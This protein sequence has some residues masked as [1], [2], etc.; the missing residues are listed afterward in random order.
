MKRNLIRRIVRLTALLI[1]PIA[2]FA[3]KGGNASVTAG[4]NFNFDTGQVV[5]SGGDL[6]FTGSSLTYVGSAKGGVLPGYTGSSNY[7]LVTPTILQSLA[8]LASNTAI[9]SSSLS[10]GTANGS[11]LGLATNGG[12]AAKI[13]ITGLGPTSIS[14]EYLTYGA[15]GTPSL[16]TI[17]KILNN[18]S[19]TPAGFVNSGIAPSSIATIFGTNLSGPAPNPLTLNTSAGSGL[20]TLSN[21]AQVTISVGGKTFNAGIYYAIPTQMAVVIPASIPTGTV[22]VTVSNG[23]QTS[24][25][26][27]V[28][29]VPAALGLDTYYGIGAGLITATDAITGALI[30]PTNS[31]KPG[32][33]ITLWGSG[34]GSD[35]QDS[36][37]VFTTTP[38]AVN[39]SGVQI[40][41]GG[42][43]APIQYAGSSG[44]PGSVQ[45]NTTVPL[46]V[47]G[48]AVSVA[49]VVN[50][51]P[52]NFGT[53]PVATSSECSD[54]LFGITGSLLSALGG[55]SAVRAG[56]LSLVQSVSPNSSGTGTSTNNSAL[57][58]FHTVT[59]AIFGGTS[60]YVSPGGCYVSQTVTG[61]G[62]STS[63]GL[64]AGSI[65]LAG[66]GG[67]TY[68]LNELV[69]S[70]G[71]Y[72]VQLPSGAITTAGGTY[73]A[74]GGGGADVGRFTSTI[75]LPNPLL[76][77]TNQSAATTVIRSNG[78]SITWSGGT[79]GSYVVIQ[80]TS[81]NATTG[82]SGS[83]T[84]YA[85]QSALAFTA[86]SYVTNAVPAGT[87]TLTVQNGTKFDTF[88]ASGL[89]IGYAF[90]TAGFGENVTYQ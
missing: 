61:G 51:I 47:S 11:I 46:G 39:Q 56:S 52:S 33:I 38:H 32:Q 17:T 8:A 43:P 74:T 23:G 84:C 79:A 14:F 50:G 10:V 48:C 21:G 2:A 37:T 63:T 53:I 19:Y 44:Y 28:P 80:G 87:G 25:P 70:K 81:S 45:I 82:A 58:T 16:P 83:F 89:D 35:P 66:P 5:T 77:W 22:S 13:L 49:A 76:S 27:S 78:Q 73:V 34:L 40:F 67:A 29:I 54:P 6:S 1:F 24:S 60:S 62:S 36:D 3:D 7:D 20:P 85:P 65:T 59:G 12:N 68:S 57:A 55:Q 18:Y 72:F 71:S 15:S 64:D 86:P 4:H 90:A 88:T 31:A 30:T 69:T 75:T 26:I 9:P 42:V 41:F